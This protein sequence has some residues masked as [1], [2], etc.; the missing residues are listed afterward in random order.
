MHELSVSTAIVDTAIRH[1]AGRRVTNVHVMVGRLRQVV[2]SSLAFYWDF[3]TRET[4]CEGSSLEQELVPA[5][6]RCERCAWSW[7]VEEP[8]FR[9]PACDG[10]GVEILQ[11]NELQVQSIDVEVEEQCTA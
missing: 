8:A 3:V 5:R 4:V 1:A 10:A 9:C 6:L 2:P 7:E 11:G